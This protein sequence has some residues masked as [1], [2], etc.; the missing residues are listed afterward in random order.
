M[1][2]AAFN[3]FT[4][5]WSHTWHITNTRCSKWTFNIKHF[6]LFSSVAIPVS[7]DVNDKTKWPLHSN[8]HKLLMFL[9]FMACLPLS[10]QRS[11]Y[12]VDWSHFEML[13]FKGHSGTVRSQHLAARH[14][15]Y[16]SVDILWACQII[17]ACRNLFKIS[18]V[19]I[20]C[21]MF[22]YVHL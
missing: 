21:F 20:H 18:M 12:D 9:F 16:S 13:K 3:N 7:G 1:S 14:F 11:D 22:Y 5:Q 6:S 2:L 10:K 17:H 8:K 4:C 15:P 19:L